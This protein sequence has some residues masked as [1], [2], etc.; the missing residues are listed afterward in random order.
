MFFLTIHIKNLL[1][2]IAA[3]KRVGVWIGSKCAHL[4]QV[5]SFGARVGLWSMSKRI[6]MNICFP[7]SVTTYAALRFSLLPGLGLAEKL[8]QLL[9][10]SRLKR[11]VRGEMHQGEG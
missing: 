5:C 3:C 2:H 8:F 4:E 9:L 1:L 7:L 10:W 6:S 11:M